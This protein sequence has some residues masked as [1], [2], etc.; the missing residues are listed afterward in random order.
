MVCVTSSYPLTSKK[1][2]I[3]FKDRIDIR[4]DNSMGKTDTSVQ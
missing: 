3:V 1:N 2:G 4:Y